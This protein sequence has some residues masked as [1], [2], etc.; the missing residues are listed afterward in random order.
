MSTKSAISL[1]EYLR[2]S[3]EWDREYID[4]EIVEIPEYDARIAA[5]ELFG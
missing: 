4:G 2:T 5:A 3:F 1:E